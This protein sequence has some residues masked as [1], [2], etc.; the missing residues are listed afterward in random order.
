MFKLETKL[1]LNK[2][3]F[4]NNYSEFKSLL[5]EYKAVLNK[6]TNGGSEKAKAI[7]KKRG[8][9][10]ARERI[11]LLL[12]PNTPFLELS[13]LAAYNQYDNNFPSAGIVTGLGVVHGKEVIIIANDATVKGGTYIQESIKKHL[14]AQEI[15]MENN[16]PCIYMVDSGGVFLP[17][18][19]K[20]FA[21]KDD[22]G[23]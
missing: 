5:D 8:K 13:P 2:E 14:R 18:Q 23:R 6:T 19:S 21:D 20:V 22:F 15:A 16:L 4:K 1:N 17:E 10:L 12:D 9:L 3:T 7:H 11:D